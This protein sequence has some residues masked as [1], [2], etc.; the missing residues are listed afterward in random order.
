MSEQ[1]KTPS[2]ALD[3]IDRVVGRVVYI[4][5]ATV[6]FMVVLTGVGV[7]YRYFLGHPINWAGEVNGLALSVSVAAAI[8]YGARRGAH[9][10]VDVLNMVGGRG[11]TR[12]TDLIVRVMAIAIIC[13]LF[14]GLWRNGMCNVNIC[15]FTTSSLSIPHNMFYYALAI[16]FGLYGVVLLIE[17]LVGLQHFRAPI[18]PSEKAN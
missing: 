14:Y 7:F 8:A 6:V 3:F 18:D 2:R 9:V 10:A 17:L 4:G 5:A 15:A 12:W 16:G 11:V 1:T 13:F